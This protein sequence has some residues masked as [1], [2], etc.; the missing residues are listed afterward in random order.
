MNQLIFGSFNPVTWLVSKAVTN[1][2]TAAVFVG[3][4]IV[5]P[6]VCVGAVVVAMFVFVSVAAN[7]AASQTL[8]LPNDA[9]VT[10]ESVDDVVV[11]GQG[12]GAGHPT[13]PVPKSETVSVRSIRVH[14]SIEADLRRLFELAD[15]EGIV[16]GGGGWRDNANQRRLYRKNCSSGTCRPPTAVPGRSRHER[17][18]AI[19]FTANGKGIPSRDTTGFRFLE[20]NAPKVGLCNFPKEPWHWS[21]DCR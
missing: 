13:A 10:G 20:R 18:T 14:H 4:V 8:T 2:K 21:V 7:P 3:V 15:A 9:S 6:V 11:V 12:S 17:G 16:L 5:T 19:D 1:P